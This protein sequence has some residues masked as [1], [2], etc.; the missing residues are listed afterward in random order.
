MTTQVPESMLVDPPLTA[1]ESL[2][3]ANII[4]P[5]GTVIDYA[6]TLEPA[7]VQG[8]TWAY[9]YGQALSRTTYATLFARLGT[10]YGVGNG[11]T[12]FNLPDYRG[13]V[14]AGRDDMGAVS[15]DRITAGIAGFN[16]DTLGASGG[17]QRLHQHNHAVTDPGHLHVIAPPSSSDTTSSGLTATGAGGGEM[18]TQY[19]SNTAITNI[20]LADSGTG[21]SQNMQ[22]T[23]IVNKL[24]RIL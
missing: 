4:C 24:I 11:T 21:S 1:A 22:P 8:V 9:P 10:T 17:D 23:L 14:G 5:I 3:L 16:G 2:A 20:S 6:G 13:R 19:N 18:V 7:A 12:T 15:A